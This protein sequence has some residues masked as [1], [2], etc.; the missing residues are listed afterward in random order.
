MVTVFGK[1]W[2]K[3]IWLKLGMSVR[4]METQISEIQK[5][6]GYDKQD[7]TCFLKDTENRPRLLSAPELQAIVRVE[8]SLL[9][10]D[11]DTTS[12]KRLENS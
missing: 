4:V 10:G 1:M 11:T 6:E 9:N 5:K 8:S 3:F 12:P 7:C 2:K